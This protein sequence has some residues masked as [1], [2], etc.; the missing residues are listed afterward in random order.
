M[1]D[2]TSSRLYLSLMTEIAEEHPELRAAAGVLAWSH[3]ARIYRDRGQPINPSIVTS[4]LRQ[5]AHLEV[6]EVEPSDV[7]VAEAR[8]VLL[9]ALANRSEIVAVIEEGGSEAVDEAG[10]PTTGPISA[11]ASTGA[12]ERVIEMENTQGTRPEE[13]VVEGAV[14]PPVGV[15]DATRKL[16]GGVAAGG[17]AP[18]RSRIRRF[19][20]G[21]D[22]GEHARWRYGLV[23]VVAAVVAI[24]VAFL[25]AAFRYDS[26]DDVSAALAAITGTLGTILGSYLGVQ[27]G[28]QGTANAEEARQEAEQARQAAE[29]RAIQFAALVEPSRAEKLPGLF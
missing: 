17:E 4:F 11:P 12:S 2:S 6:P 18:P 28:A 23:A 16:H 5:R 27:V 9:S 25:I 8:R 29:L 13:P 19:L 14:R 26:A 21:D 22:G 7:E 10:A 1:V 3:A 24:L 20:N 15:Q